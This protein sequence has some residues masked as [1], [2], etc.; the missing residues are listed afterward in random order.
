MKNIFIY[1]SRNKQN[2]ISKNPYMEDLYDSCSK[3][4]KIIN[5]NEANALGVFNIFIKLK[6]IDI[7]WLNW[8]ENLPDR[9]L[10]LLQSLLYLIFI[11]L[12]KLLNK[13]VIYTV[14]NKVSH[15]LKYFKLKR[16]LQNITIN[17]SVLVISHS[18]DG[19]EY[20]KNISVNKNHANLR[21]IPHP[22]KIALN[23]NNHNIIK[24]KYDILI[25]G[26]IYEYKGIREFLEFIY[27]KNLQNNYNIKIIGKIVDPRYSEIVNKF[28]NEFI[29]I[30]NKYASQ[31]E[32][33]NLLQISKIVI[34]T[35]NSESVFSS[36]SLI[37]TLRYNI[38]VIGPNKGE[39]KDLFQLGLIKTYVNY[40]D[41]VEKINI[42]LN[43]NSSIT[44]KREMEIEKYL[45]VNNWANYLTRIQEIL[46]H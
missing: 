22:T 4:W 17:N 39:F 6:H 14:H 11:F 33:I 2:T 21:Y 8:I 36:G 40:E 9:K 42:F 15:S 18:S 5:Y 45:L 13:E 26:T 41:L 35:Y 20:I 1:P 30:E 46:I 34:F 10:G 12:N 32:L 23:N 29:D 25:W 44:Q 31:E 37:E 28:E 38:N 19:L 27:E 3:W 16:I 43:E 24:Y 7:I